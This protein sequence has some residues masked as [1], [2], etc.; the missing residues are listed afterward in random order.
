MREARVSYSRTT[1]VSLPRRLRVF[2]LNYFGIARAK[3]VTLLPYA[4]HR[5]TPNLSTVSIVLRR[6]GM[7]ELN[8]AY[9]CKTH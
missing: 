9:R 3:V 4:L 7:S 1:C 6:G 2:R 8:C 5:D